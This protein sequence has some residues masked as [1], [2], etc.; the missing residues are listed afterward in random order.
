MADAVLPQVDERREQLMEDQ[1]GFPLGQG[2]VAVDAIEEL[3][4][5]AVLHHNVNGS[6]SADDL[7]YLGDVLV[8][9]RP[10]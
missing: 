2:P 9:Q 8:K 5:V 4:V 3:S 7:V 10:L 6:V 1:G